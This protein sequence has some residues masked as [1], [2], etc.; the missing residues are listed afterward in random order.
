MNAIISRI[1]SGDCVSIISAALPNIMIM[2]FISHSSI[3]APPNG[4]VHTRVGAA[5]PRSTSGKT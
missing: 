5:A 3:R 1:Q 4:R 2:Y